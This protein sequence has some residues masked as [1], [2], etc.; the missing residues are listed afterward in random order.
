MYA[1]PINS[2]IGQPVNG[3][4]VTLIQKNGGTLNLALA[5]ITVTKNGGAF[6]K[7]RDEIAADGSLI[8]TNEAQIAEV[9]RDAAVSQGL[10]DVITEEV[11]QAFEDFEPGTQG[12]DIV[13][14]FNKFLLSDGSVDKVK[15]G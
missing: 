15:L 10:E 6:A 14:V 12:N 5:K 4:K 7:W 9:I 2:G 1:L 13:N 3:Q 11:A 8:L